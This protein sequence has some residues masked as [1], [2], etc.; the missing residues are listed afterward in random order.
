MLQLITMQRSNGISS[1]V[2]M[3]HGGSMPKRPGVWGKSSRVHG[4]GRQAHMELAVI[5]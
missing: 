2:P 3:P 4:V 1:A 5:F